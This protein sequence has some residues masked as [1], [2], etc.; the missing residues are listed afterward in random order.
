MKDLTS[1]RQITRWRSFA[2]GAREIEAGTAGDSRLPKTVPRAESRSLR[3]DGRGSLLEGAAGLT[4]KICA[5]LLCAML[6]VGAAAA[7]TPY[8]PAVHARQLQPTQQQL[9]NQWDRW[10]NQVA[11]EVDRLYR[12]I[13]RAAMK[14]GS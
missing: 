14:Q 12:Q 5:F 9:E 10:N 3:I 13:M 1:P 2:E 6:F 8:R 11:P 7:Q 4:P